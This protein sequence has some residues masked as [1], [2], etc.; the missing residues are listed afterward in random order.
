MKAPIYQMPSL[1][2]ENLPYLNMI[3]TKLAHCINNIEFG[4]TEAAENVWCDLVT[5]DAV[6]AANTVC[7]A[8][9]GLGRKPVGTI[10][11]W[12]D[13][14]ANMFKPTAAA[15]ADTSTAVFYAFNVS[16]TSTATSAVS[17]ILLLI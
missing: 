5:V 11:V 17:A 9:H 13:T 4:N 15:S 8:G 3:L 12:Q 6:S 14:A 16:G 2:A 1:S 10:V 7:S